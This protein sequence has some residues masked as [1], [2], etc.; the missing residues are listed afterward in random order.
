MKRLGVEIALVGFALLTRGLMG[1]NS[2]VVF[3]FPVSQPRDCPQTG[4]AVQTHDPVTR[5]SVGSHMSCSIHRTGQ[6]RCWGASNFLQSTATAMPPTVLPGVTEA[7]AVGLFLEHGCVLLATGEVACWGW[8]HHLQLGSAI[9]RGAVVPT[10]TLVPGIEAATQLA[11]QHHQNCVVTRSGHVRCW[12]GAYD[13][14]L[15]DAGVWES[16]TPVEVVGVDDAAEVAGS[17]GHTCVLRGS[18]K[19]QCWG[20]NHSGQL[21]DGTRKR[22]PEPVDVLGLEGNVVQLAVGWHHSC[23]LLS[24]GTVWCWG[25]N[26]SGQLAPDVA[27]DLLQ[28]TRISAIDDA[29]ALAAGQTN[30]CVVRACGRV[31]CFPYDPASESGFE[32]KG[33]GPVSVPELNGVIQIAGQANHYC[34]LRLD[35]A[36]LCWGDNSHGKLGGSSPAS[37]AVPVVVEGLE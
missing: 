21:G 2:E 13:A 19:V 14:G 8:N 30:T 1:C 15:G 28:P 7:V 37:S 29:T 10:P 36:V 34:A 6:V 20:S 17:I 9:P 31:S 22:R 23:A 35:G 26:G 16:A 24:N 4:P 27:G 32:A 5:V 18:G 33:T 12:G 3:D 11:V 25:D